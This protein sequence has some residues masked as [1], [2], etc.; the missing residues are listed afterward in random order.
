MGG[1]L[2]GGTAKKAVGVNPYKDILGIVSKGYNEVQ[3]FALTQGQDDQ[4]QMHQELHD[5]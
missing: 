3:K 1:G 2:L 4:P 5:R